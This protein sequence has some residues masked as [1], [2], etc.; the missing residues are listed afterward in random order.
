MTWPTLP[1]S[2]EW[3]HSTCGLAL[4]CRPLEALAPH[5]FTTRGVPLSA[6]DDWHRVA[7]AV[8]A[9]QV[10]TPH[11]VHGRHVVAIRRGL[12]LPTE[13]PT[14]DVLVSND[15]ATAVAVRAADCVPLLLADARP[16]RWPPFTPGGAEWRP[17]PS[18]RPSTRWNANSPLSPNTCTS[19]S[20]RVSA[21]AAMRLVLSLSMRSP[22]QGMLDIWSTG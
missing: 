18:W 17:A 20:A 8:G 9:E 19:P 2:F 10:V 14:C 1:E 11:Q 6:R 13:K 12:P 5:L 4:R 16:V 22:P 21:H 7:R 3:V 15:P